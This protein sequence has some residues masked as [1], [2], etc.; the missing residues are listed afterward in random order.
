LPTLLDYKNAITAHGI[1]SV[2]TA[3]AITAAINAARRR[4]VRAHRWKSLE[5]IDSTLTTTAGSS[6]VALP[7]PTWR[8][9]A[10]RVRD[11]AF[12]YHELVYREPEEVRRLR[13]L[14]SDP[15]VPAYWSQHAKN[16]IL[17]PIPDATYTVA[18]DYVSSAVPSLVSDSDTDTVLTTDITLDAVAWAATRDLAV[19]MRDYNLASTAEAQYQTEM[20]LAIRQDTTPQRQQARQ[21]QSN[22]DRWSGWNA[23]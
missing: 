14:D 6:T 10:V 18:I 2:T 4:V 9:D 8:I 17:Y 3:S 16:L 11:A 13:L 5:V 20:A 19:R 22:P 21:V 1:E 7:D 23:G 15:G 12:Q